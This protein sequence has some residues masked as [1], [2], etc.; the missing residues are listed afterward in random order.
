MIKESLNDI[1]AFL[2]VARERSFTR[3]AAKLGVS[4]SAL[5]HTIRLLEERLGVRRKSVLIVASLVALLSSSERLIAQTSGDSTI[6]D[7]IHDDS[8]SHLVLTSHAVT[9]AYTAR[10][11]DEHRRHTDSVTAGY[12]DHAMASLVRES[13]NGAFRGMRFDFGLDQIA[14]ARVERNTIVLEFKTS[15]R[16]HTFDFDAAD[17][18]AAQSFVD[19]LNS[20]L[21]ARR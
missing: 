11:L 17:A 9:F 15:A 1:Q 21:A 12:S 6:A 3:A 8:T 7:L 19:K 18:G 5:S 10:G 13:I 14:S 16:D 2:T 20:V 4:Q